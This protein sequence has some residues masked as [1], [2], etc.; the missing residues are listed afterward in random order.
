MNDTQL[1][2]WLVAHG[3]PIIVDGQA[4]PATR[5]AIERA[6]TNTC[7]PAVTDDDIAAFAQ[8]LKCSVRQIKAVAKVESGGA[9]FDDKGRPKILF[10][11]HLFHRLTDGR[12]SVAGFSNPKG[13]GY[14]DCSWKK[15]TEAACKDAD[16]A[17]AAVSWGRFQVLGTH[18]R[19]LGYPS[20]IDLAYS[21]VATEAA[22]YELLIRYVEHNGLG[23]ALRALSADPET[24]RA[25]ARGYNGPAYTKFDY[26]TKLARALA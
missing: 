19:A 20:S 26:H 21:A 15:L 7:A 12:Y 5:A 22:H 13:G 4:G 18:W 11:R 16:A 1:Q 25:F 9:A 24:C 23:G 10:E 3:Q 2:Q 14:S 6:F 17:F 8:R